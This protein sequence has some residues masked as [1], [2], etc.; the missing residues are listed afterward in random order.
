MICV[1][2]RLLEVEVP[3]E[4]PAPRGHVDVHLVRPRHLPL[5]PEDLSLPPQFRTAGDQR[6]QELDL[7]QQGPVISKPTLIDRKICNPIA[8]RV[9]TEAS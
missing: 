4:E 8:L 3:L 9:P 6:V 2:H 7:Q 1:G 5:L